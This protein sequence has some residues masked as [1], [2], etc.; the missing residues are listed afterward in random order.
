[1]SNIKLN[2]QDFSD[3]WRNEDI[4][5]INRDVDVGEHLPQDIIGKGAEF[6]LL[7]EISN[8]EFKKLWET[9]NRV[10]ENMFI[11]KSDDMGIDKYIQLIDLEIGGSLEEKRKQVFL[12][13]NR[14]TIWTHR[15]LEQYLDLALGKGFYEITLY[16]D[17]YG[18]WIDVTISRSFDLDKIYYVLRAEILPANLD[19]QLRLNF[20]ADLILESQLG[21]YT[22][23]QFLCGLHDTGTI[24]RIRWEGQA[25]VI[26]VNLDTAIDDAKNYKPIS[27]EK[28]TATQLYNDRVVETINMT[29]FSSSNVYSFER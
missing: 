4:I 23:P 11:Q 3:L 10:I 13:W 19:I 2:L 14:Q 20:K 21:D 25:A 6:T 18:I 8:A 7:R 9:A 22:Y 5:S 1:M 26:D 15:T 24:P 27:G 16:Y 28:H 12:E 17:E 29:S